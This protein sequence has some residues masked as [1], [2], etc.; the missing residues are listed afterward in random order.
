MDAGKIYFVEFVGVLENYQQHVGV[1]LTKKTTPYQ[2]YDVA[3]S[4]IDKPT[5]L[6]VQEYNDEVQV[7]NLYHLE[8]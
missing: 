5:W 8:S 7:R 4:R 2:P 6:W 3:Q 1:G